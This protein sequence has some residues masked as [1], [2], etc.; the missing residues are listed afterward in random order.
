M[1]DELKHVTQNDFFN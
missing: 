1:Q